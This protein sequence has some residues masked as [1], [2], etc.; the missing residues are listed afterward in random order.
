MHVKI[1]TSIHLFDCLITPILLYGCEVSNSFNIS[2]AMKKNDL[3]FFD[4]ILK[5]KQERAHLNFGRYILGVNS[6]TANMAILGELGRYPLFIKAMKQ[7]WKYHQRC[8]DINQETLLHDGYVEQIRNKDN[9]CNKTSWIH[10]VRFISS[11]VGIENIEEDYCTKQAEEKM[12]GM[13]REHWKNKLFNDERKE[14]YGNKLRTYREFKLIY[15][16][17]PYLNSVSHF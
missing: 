8:K 16:V 12:K 1:K 4:H 5:W 15:E 14:G 7:I 17:E 3:A 11:K 2:K 6:K 10:F 13:F 9:N